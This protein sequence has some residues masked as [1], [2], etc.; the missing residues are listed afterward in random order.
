MGSLPAL[1]SDVLAFWAVEVCFRLSA[2]LLT[3]ARLFP[4][5]RDESFS[6]QWWTRGIIEEKEAQ[7]TGLNHVQGVFVPFGSPRHVMSGVSGRT[8]RQSAELVARACVKTES[9]L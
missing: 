4:R 6:P 2:L 7:S 8:P 1:Q 3:L 9:L 5:V